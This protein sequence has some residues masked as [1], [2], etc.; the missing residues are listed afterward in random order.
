MGLQLPT[1]AAFEQWF[2]AKGIH[3]PVKCEESSGATIP[4]ISQ[5]FQDRSI[6]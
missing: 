4:G 2:G 5:A 3:L 6:V 1:A